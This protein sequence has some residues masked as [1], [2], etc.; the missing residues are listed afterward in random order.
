MVAIGELEE[1]EIYEVQVKA[2]VD[3]ETIGAALHQPPIEIV[4]RSEYEQYD[5]YFLF[6]DR[7][8]GH[9]RYREDIPVGQGVEVKPGYRLTLMGPTKE[10]EYADSV[11]LRRLRFRSAAD[12][13][14]R[15]YREYFQPDEIK[16]ITKHR[17]RLHIMY[18]GVRFEINLDRLLE[19]KHDQVLLEIKSRTWSSSDA[20]RKAQLLTELLDVL[21]VDR[22]RLVKREYVDF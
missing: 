6:A 8:K 4:R 2:E 3:E 22:E 13:S 10:R 14:L 17:R 5:T 15:F 1:R 20:E 16:E 11:I 21:G 7:S 9:L 12:R 18:K 19:P